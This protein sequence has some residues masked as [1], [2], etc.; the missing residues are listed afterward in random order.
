VPGPFSAHG[1]FDDRSKEYSVELWMAK[2]KPWLEIAGAAMLGV[3]L[4]LSST[5]NR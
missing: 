3:A 1:R 2:R 4:G 5:R